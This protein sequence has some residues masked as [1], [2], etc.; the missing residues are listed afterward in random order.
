MEGFLAWFFE[1]SLLVIM[2]L[3]IRR[4]FMGKVRYAAIYA[5]WAV[6]LLRFL[7]P[8]NIIP[9][10]VNVGNIIF[11]AIL[12]EISSDK[13]LDNTDVNTVGNLSQN[14]TIKVTETE[15]A[16]E[17][18]HGINVPENDGNNGFHAVKL[19]K[20]HLIIAS[21]VISVILFAWIIMSNI[22]MSRKLKR[23]RVLY[24]SCG[25]V[26]IYT[27]SCIKRP[28]LYGFFHPAIYFPKEIYAD[29]E[30]IEQIIT[31]EY[32]HYMHKDH[33]WAMFRIILISVYWF[34]PFLWIA[35]F[36]SKKDA[37][38]FCDET[39]ISY[40]GEDNRFCYG[41]TLIKMARNPVPG[42]FFCQVMAMSRKGRELEKR[43]YAI[44]NRKHYS[45]WLIIPLIIGVCF[46]VMSTCSTGVISL[47]DS[48]KEDAAIKGIYNTISGLEHVVGIDLDNVPYIRDTASDA[49]DR[50]YSHTY[51]EA[52]ENYVHTF[53]NAVNTGNI[54]QLDQVLAAGSDVYEQQCYMANNY[55]SRGIREEVK[56][57]SIASVNNISDENAEQVE[58]ISKE[59]INVFYADASEKIVK[60]K[61]RYRCEKIDGNWYITRMDEV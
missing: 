14:N 43:I 48:V 8:V 36:C 60:Q 19:K 44:S 58:I 15:N 61:Y 41:A 30:E 29:S 11:D 2:I 56:S 33:I 54:D 57:C 47:A 55:Y 1:S 9:A 4:I 37:E 46:V 17:V 20:S 34:H 51:E 6:V 40:I 7:I 27:G 24:R 3:G 21:S 31:H 38:L 10:P 22:C 18:Y 32:V 26:I 50:I 23:N 59:K 5:L 25:K 53:I 35:A 28:C 16:S 45:G 12:S 52:F 49:E 39:V 13:H 42:E